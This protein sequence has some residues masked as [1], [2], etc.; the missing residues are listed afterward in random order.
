MRRIPFVILLIVL[1][2]FTQCSPQWR[3]NRILKK[4]PELIRIDTLKKESTFVIQ[5]VV[6]SEEIETFEKLPQTHSLDSSFFQATIKADSKG[7]ILQKMMKDY[8]LVVRRSTTED[9]KLKPSGLTI[10]A[11][12]KGDTIR[13]EIQFPDKSVNQIVEKKTGILFK[14]FAISIGI[15]FAMTFILIVLTRR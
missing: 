7:V 11:K 12:T 15:I 10:E 8:T 3:I 9:G 2:I 5:P 13:K 14:Y 4:H 6:M 1:L